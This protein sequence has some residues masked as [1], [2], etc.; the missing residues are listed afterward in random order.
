MEFGSVADW[1]A[2]IG[3]F[4]AAIAAVVAWQVNR[5]ML[6]VEEE[7]D[8]RADERERRELYREKRE[9]AGLV[10]ALGAKLPD[11]PKGED[12]AIYLFNG[13][14]K[15]V[16][17]VRVES[18]RLN[19]SAANYPLEIGALPPGRFVVP[20]HPKFHWGALADLSLANEQVDFLV[21]GKGKEMITSMAFADAD[22]DHWALAGGTAI[23]D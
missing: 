5:R 14:T 7:R 9:Q 10:F 15:P 22:G 13:S 20:S 19:G 16:Y 3:G 2:G 1:L 18:Q 23:Q 6:I 11:R 12:W 17:N 21:K 4:L 8:A